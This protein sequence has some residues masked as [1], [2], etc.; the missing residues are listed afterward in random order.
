MTE[1]IIPEFQSLNQ[2]LTLI[3]KYKEFTI[4]D[5]ETID[6]TFARFNTVITSLKAL[7]ESFSNRNHVRKFLRALP[8]AWRPKVTKV[9]E[10]KDLSTPPLDEL[11][12]NSNV[13]EVVLEKDL[14]ASKNKNE[15]YKSLALKAKKYLVTKGPRIPVVMRHMQWRVKEEKKGKEERICFKCGDPNHFISDC[16]KHSFNDQ[17][18]FVGGCWSDSE[19]EDNTKKDEIFLMALDNNEIS[20]RKKGLGFTEDRA[21]TNEAK[22]GKLGLEDGKKP[23]VEPA[24][25]VPC[26]REPACTNLRNQ[27]PVEVR[28]KVKLKPDEWIKDSGC[29]R[30]M[31]GNKDLFSTYEAINRGKICDKKC[32]V[33]SSKTDSEI[34][35]DGIT[36]GREIRKNGLYMMKMENSPKDS[37]CLTSIDDTST[38]W[39]QRLGHANMRFI[40]SISSKELVRD[41]PKLKFKSHFVTLVT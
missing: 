12:R 29:T 38:L 21:S 28:L 2:T 26:V 10:S 20:K 6:Y 13:Y 18:A 41:L 33:L 14:E 23:S 4:S 7:D 5:D 22:L 31:M 9:E 39:H 30:H 25:L 34:L 8:T 27:P 37:L 17:K 1:N 32:K 3:Q 19:E 40:P 24:E 11:I 15:K 36:I 35:K 16:P